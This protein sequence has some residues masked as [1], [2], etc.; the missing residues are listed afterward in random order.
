M[1]QVI[2]FQFYD[3][4]IKSK[5]PQKMLDVKVEFQFYDSPIKRRQ[6]SDNLHELL[7]SILW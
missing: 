3:S 5:I 2:T 4:P 6:R 7:V 1:M